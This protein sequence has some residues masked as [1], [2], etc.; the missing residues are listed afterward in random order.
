MLMLVMILVCVILL[1]ICFSFLKD[2]VLNGFQGF[3]FEV[4]FPVYIFCYL[5]FYFKVFFFNALFCSVLMF[6]E[7]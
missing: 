3:Q 6:L 7:F 4:I 2:F 5:Q 1:N